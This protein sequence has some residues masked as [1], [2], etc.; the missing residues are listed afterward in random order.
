MNS[1]DMREERKGANMES[2]KF[3]AMVIKEIHNF[4][5]ENGGIESVK[6]LE[7]LKRRIIGLKI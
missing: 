6:D 7:E 4:W 5:L 2:K 3:K 1:G